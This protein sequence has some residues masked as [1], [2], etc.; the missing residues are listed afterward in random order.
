MA[1]SFDGLADGVGVGQ[2]AT[3]DPARFWRR[4]ESAT[5]YSPIPAGAPSPCKAGGMGHT[6]QAS[7]GAPARAAH[8]LD[9]PA[10]KHP[11]ALRAAMSIN[12]VPPCDALMRHRKRNLARQIPCNPA[13]RNGIAPVRQ[14]RGAYCGKR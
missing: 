10:R 11:C 7:P 8:R 3:E 14:K 4:P 12:L 13:S 1:L 5:S 6:G 9:R 2:A